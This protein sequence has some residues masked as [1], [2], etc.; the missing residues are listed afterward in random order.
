MKNLIQLFVVLA[1]A[2]ITGCATGPSEKPFNYNQTGTTK[3]SQYVNGQL[4]EVERAEYSESMDGKGPIPL[5]LKRNPYMGP[6]GRVVNPAG[7]L[8]NP[9]APAPAQQ[10]PFVPQGQN[11]NNPFIPKAQGGQGSYVPGD[12]QSGQA[13]VASQGVPANEYRQRYSPERNWGPV[14]YSDPRF[15]GDPG[16]AAYFNSIQAQGGGSNYHH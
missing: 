5:G 10:N 16:Y 7:Q 9:P 14:A 6:P 15:A 2:T 1:V 3:Y 8:V 4:V 12:Q 11:P 13:M